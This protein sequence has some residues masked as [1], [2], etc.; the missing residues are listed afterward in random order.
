MTIPFHPLANLFPLIEGKEFDELVAD[1]RENGLLEPIVLLDGQILDG[2]NRYRAGLEAKVLHAQN[3]AA[4][5]GAWEAGV[6]VACFEKFDR[7]VSGDPL[8][9]VLSKNLHRRHLSENQRTMI[10]AEIATMRQGRPS[11][12]DKDREDKPANRRDLSQDE[13][14]ELLNVSTRSVQRGRQVIERGAPELVNAVKRD[15]IAVSAAAEVAKLSPADQLEV[16]RSVP[17]HLVAKVAK[18]RVGNGARSVNAGRLEPADSLDFFPTPPWAT[19]ALIETVLADRTDS[20][21]VLTVWEPACGE[22]HI[23]GVLEEYFGT[24]IATDIFDYSQD[25]RSAPGWRG[26]LDFLGTDSTVEDLAESEEP[27]WIISNWPFSGDIDRALACTLRALPL[28]RI[29]VAA[30]VRTQWLEGSERY[31]ELFRPHPP[32]IFAQ[33]VERVPLHRGRWEPEG[34]TMSQYCWL[35]WVKGEAPRVPFWIPPGQRSLCAD[36]RD[37]ERFTARPVLPTPEDLRVTL[38]FPADVEAPRATPG[39][40]VGAGGDANAP[41]G[42][43]A[44]GEGGV[45]TVAD[46]PPDDDLPHADVPVEQ[47][48]KDQQ[49]DIIRAGYTRVPKVTA[50]ELMLFTGLKRSTIEM[51]AK[52]MDLTDPVNRLNAVNELNRRRAAKQEPTHAA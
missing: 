10:A 51:R 6:A 12:W 36:D 28:A 2:R 14:A 24:V 4:I 52:A 43:A 1:V 45:V 29:G 46:L 30:F 3:S 22:G 41:Q 38:E 17:P 49:N 5:L 11:E 39:T 21:S 50:V 23:S 9:W 25:G 7:D 8:S 18:E 26:K 35:V 31:R 37:V 47:L 20:L 48:T 27:D 16:L 42:A 13:A 44:E 32:T 33:F 15:E 34:D 40:D 19:R